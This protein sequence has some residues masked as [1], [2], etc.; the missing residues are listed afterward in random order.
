[1]FLCC[2]LTCMGS[3]ARASILAVV[4]ALVDLAPLTDVA[5]L[6]ATLGHLASVEEAASAVQTLDI[7]GLGGRSCWESLAVMKVA[8]GSSMRQIKS[9]LCVAPEQMLC[10]PPATRGHGFHLQTSLY[11][12]NKVLRIIGHLFNSIS[13]RPLLP[14][15]KLFHKVCNFQLWKQITPNH[16]LNP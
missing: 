9:D 12:Q 4:P 5:R 2:V 3:S 10:C 14:A 13:H 15:F 11:C 1:M 16:I 8:S 6:A 7:T